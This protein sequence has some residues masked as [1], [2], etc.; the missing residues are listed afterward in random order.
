M[1]DSVL[2]S[3]NF[4]KQGFLSARDY[5]FG[6]SAKTYIYTSFSLFVCLGSVPL[7]NEVIRYY[8]DI[9]CCFLNRGVEYGSISVVGGGLKRWVPLG[10][11]ISFLVTR[12]QYPDR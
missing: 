9:L 7:T 5:C 3:Y 1:T 6:V 11:H 12:I 2:D 8:G 4:L 10:W